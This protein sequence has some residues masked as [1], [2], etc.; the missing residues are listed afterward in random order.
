MGEADDGDRIQPLD[1]DEW[2]GEPSLA[3][4][5]GRAGARRHII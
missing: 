1:F 3:F 2:H 5:A 4:R